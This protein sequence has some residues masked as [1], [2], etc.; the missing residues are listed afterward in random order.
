MTYAK[1][2]NCTAQKGFFQHFLIITKIFAKESVQNIGKSAFSYKIFIYTLYMLIQ[3]DVMC[4]QTIKYFIQ[5]LLYCP[6]YR[7]VLEY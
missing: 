3:T 2:N 5:Y 1:K 4:F 6:I 7:R